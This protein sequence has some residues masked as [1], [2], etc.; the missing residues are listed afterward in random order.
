MTLGVHCVFGSH[1]ILQGFVQFWPRPFPLE[2]PI[3]ILVCPQRREGLWRKRTLKEPSLSSHAHQHWPLESICL[4]KG[5]ELAAITNPY[6]PSG[7]QG[8]LS[9]SFS[10]DDEQELW[11]VL[12]SNPALHP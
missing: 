9:G 6:L 1:P 7:V 11:D 5:A 12:G 3:I 4:L 8:W 10:D 2:W